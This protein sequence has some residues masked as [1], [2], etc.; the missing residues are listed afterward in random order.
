MGWKPLN[1]LDETLKSMLDYWDA[2]L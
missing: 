2:V 1:S